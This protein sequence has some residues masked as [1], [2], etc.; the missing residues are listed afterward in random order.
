L[1]KEWYG[2]VELVH[3]GQETNLDPAEYR[4]L[5]R[6]LLEACRTEAA[7]SGSSHRQAAL[8]L[9]AVAEPWL[10]L[11]SMTALDRP[12]RNNLFRLCQELDPLFRSLAVPSTLRRRLAGTAGFLFLAGCAALVAQVVLT[13]GPGEMLLFIRQLVHSLAGRN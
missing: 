1:W 10:T 11:E 2:M 12:G 4:C 9:E 13:G 8:R 3:R 7:D 5:H 6:E